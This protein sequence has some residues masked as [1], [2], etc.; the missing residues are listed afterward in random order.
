MNPL[1]KS[2]QQLVVDNLDIAN[3]VASKYASQQPHVPYE[4][5]YSIALEALCVTAA[6]NSNKVGFRSR[7]TVAIKCKI[8]TYLVR[9]NLGRT[10]VTTLTPFNE[11]DEYPIETFPDNSML[12]DVES[13]LHIKMGKLNP[14]DRYIVGAVIAGDTYLSVGKEIG[15]NKRHIGRRISKI[16]KFNS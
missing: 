9:N 14:K 5:L 3:S 11:D 12:P 15:I 13:S 16:K 10:I 4:D 7:A 8:L 1:N 6:I 2:S